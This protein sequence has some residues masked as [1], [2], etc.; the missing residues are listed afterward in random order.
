MSVHLQVLSFHLAR[1]CWQVNMA[2][3][4]SVCNTEDQRSLIHFIFHRGLSY[5][6]SVEQASKEEERAGNPVP[7]TTDDNSDQASVLIR[8]YR[9]TDLK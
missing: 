1:R 8:K 2:T 6:K 9:T 7:S 3:P 4:L 5:N